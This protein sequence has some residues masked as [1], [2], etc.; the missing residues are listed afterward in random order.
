MQL[1]KLRNEDIGIFKKYS[2][3]MIDDNNEIIGGLL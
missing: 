1:I 2:Y 3:E